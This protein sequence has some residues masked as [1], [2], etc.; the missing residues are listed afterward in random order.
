[1]IPKYRDIHQQSLATFEK[2]SQNVFNAIAISWHLLTM[3][4]QNYNVHFLF[5]DNSCLL[6]VSDDLLHKESWIIWN[7]AENRNSG[8]QCLPVTQ[9]QIISDPSQYGT[10]TVIG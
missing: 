5:Y 2:R 10:H 9:I 7:V 6:H 3:W 1:M 4:S 8:T